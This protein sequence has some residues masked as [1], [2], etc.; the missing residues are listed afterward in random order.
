MYVI[1]YFTPI[2]PIFISPTY[3]SVGNLIPA[4]GLAVSLI[5]CS[6]HRYYKI[7]W[8]SVVIISGLLIQLVISLIG[9]SIFGV[10]IN[11]LIIIYIICLMA[12]IWNLYEN[13]NIKKGFKAFFKQNSKVIIH[14]GISFI[15]IGTL[16][17]SIGG[18]LQDWVYFTGFFTILLGIIPS[19]LVPFI[20]KS[21]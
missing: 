2:N 10:W 20:K 19:I 18:G 4:I 16:S 6:L 17:E 5:F 3:F 12:A 11:P 8:I 21:N 15:L 9:S 14:I 7:K 1:S 13:F